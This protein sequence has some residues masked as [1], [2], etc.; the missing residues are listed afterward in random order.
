[1]TLFV[2]LHDFQSKVLVLVYPIETAKERQM[3]AAG[4]KSVTFL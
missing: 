4:I 2:A 1:M 3:G